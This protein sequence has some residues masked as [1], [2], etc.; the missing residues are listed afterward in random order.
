MESMNKD[1][2]MD[3]LD[4]LINSVLEA[5]KKVSGTMRQVYKSVESV[6]V[7]DWFTEFCLSADRLIKA[8]EWEKEKIAA[9]QKQ[10]G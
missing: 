1:I 4:T 7:N 6:S 10:E 2:R 8:A 9:Q 3:D 5:K